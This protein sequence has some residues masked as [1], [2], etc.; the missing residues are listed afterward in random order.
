LKKFFIMKTVR[1][2]AT[3]S[4]F[5]SIMALMF[6]FISCRKD[7]IGIAETP[8]GEKQLVNVKKMREQKSAYTGQDYFEGLMFFEGNVA[9]E[10]SNLTD[11]HIS[12]FVSDTDLLNDWYERRDSIISYVAINQSDF[13]NYFETNIESGV[14]EDIE[15]AIDS[16]R[17][18]LKNAS[19][20][21]AYSYGDAMSTSNTTAAYDLSE[22]Y[23]AP[24]RDSLA[25]LD[26]ATDATAIRAEIDEAIINVKDDTDYPSLSRTCGIKVSVLIAAVIIWLIVLI[27]EAVA[28]VKDFAFWGGYEPSSSYGLWK[29]DL[30]D[31]VAT[32]F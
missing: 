7:D 28:I 12:K 14:H 23:G 21:V 27:Y 10:I 24:L 8:D 5:C 1:K 19:D 20:S 26:P 17:I 6:L 29:E 16:A 31:D 13:L 2:I 9:E 32:T 18:V 4:P 22:E 30:I 25:G 11:Y 15:A 3:S